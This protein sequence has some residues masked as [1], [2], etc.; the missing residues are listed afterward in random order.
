M[1]KKQEEDNQLFNKKLSEL[2]KIS[3]TTQLDYFFDENYCDLKDPISGQWKTGIIIQRD[4]DDIEVKFLNSNTNKTIYKYNVTNSSDKEIALFRKFTSEES[5]NFNSN[6]V[7]VKE[8]SITNTLIFEA[9][10]MIKVLSEMNDYS[11]KTFDDNFSSPLEMIQDIRGKIYYTFLNIIN[12]NFK[13]EY[14]LMDKMKEKNKNRNRRKNNKDKEEEEDEEMD[15]ET[16]INIEDIGNLLN[17]FLNFSVKFLEW[18]NSNSY[19]GKLLTFNYN[20]MLFDKECAFFSTLYEV[21]SILSQLFKENKFFQNYK[22]PISEVLK[23]WG[24]DKVDYKISTTLINITKNKG[25]DKILTEILTNNTQSLFVF[26]QLS[27][28]L[29]SNGLILLEN[30]LNIYDY[31]SN[32]I[33]NLSIN[34]QKFISFDDIEHYCDKIRRLIDAV[35]ID[36]KEEKNVDSIHLQ[37]LYNLITSNNL[38]LKIK[39]IGLISKIINDNLIDNNRLIKFIQTVHL[40]SSIILGSNIHEEILKRSYHVFSFVLKDP[41]TNNNRMIENLF[42]E[43]KNKNN[44]IA[45]EVKKILIE[46]SVYYN[47]K[48]QNYFFDEILNKINVNNF[49]EDLIDII[50]FSTINTKNNKGVDLLWKIINENEKSEIVDKSIDALSIVFKKKIFDK[51]LVYLYLI[52]S[53]NKIENEDNVQCMKV[54]KTIIQ[55]YGEELKNEIQ[56]LDSKKN[57]MNILIN[58]CNV[59]IKSKDETK[60]LSLYGQAI[61]IE[62][63]LQIIFFIY[64][65]LHK[66]NK[67]EFKHTLTS[68]W[69]IFILDENSKELE[70]NIFSRFLYNQFNYFEESQNLMEY[71]YENIIINEELN[72]TE[73]INYNIFSLFNT[74]FHKVNSLRNKFT[75]VGNYSRIKSVDDLEGFEFFWKI[76]KVTKWEKVKRGIS[77]L[78][79]NLCLNPVSLKNKDDCYSIWK[80]YYNKIYNLIKKNNG[81]ENFTINNIVYFLYQFVKIVEN[82]NKQIFVYDEKKNKYPFTINF[83]L[84]SQNITKKIPVNLEED[85]IINLREKASYY[86]KI[87]F[88]LVELK[89]KNE[90][91]SIEYED[92]DK[93]F[94]SFINSENSGS[95]EIEVNEAPN[96]LY[97]L[98]NNPKKLI[99]ENENIFNELFFLLS[100]YNKYNKDSDLDYNLINDLIY[101]YPVGKQLLNQINEFKFWEILK[102]D[103]SIYSQNY[104]IKIIKSK[105]LNNNW[106]NDLKKD[107]KL[108]RLFLNIFLQFTI[109]EDNK[110]NINEIEYS[111]LDNLLFLID[112]SCDITNNSSYYDIITKCF[113]L[114]YLIYSNKDEKVK[115]ENVIN[116][117]FS[118]INNNLKNEINDIIMNNKNDYIHKICTECL[119]HSK[120][121]AFN[122]QKIFEFLTQNT[123]DIK[124]YISILNYMFDTD[125][126]NEIEKNKNLFDDAFFNSVIMLLNK[127]KLTPEILKKNKRDILFNVNELID[128]I[129]EYIYGGIENGVDNVNILYGYLQI[130]KQ[131]CLDNIEILNKIKSDLNFF[132]KL[133]K[134]C[135]FKTQICN[136]NKNLRTI[137]YEIILI[138]TIDHDKNTKE[139]IDTLSN[140]HN[141]NFWRSNSIYDWNLIP[142]QEKN[143]INLTGLINLGMT[144]YMNSLLQQIFM[145]KE[146]RENIINDEKIKNN[147]IF[148]NLKL[149]LAQLKFSNM[150]YITTKKFFDNITNYEGTPLNAYVQMDVDEFFNLLIDKCNCDEFKNIFEGN[151]SSSYICQ[152]CFNN[153]TSIETFNA[154]DL[155]I[156]NKPNLK[157]SLD[158]FFDEEYLDGDNKYHCSKCNKKVQAQKKTFLKKLPKCLVIVLKRFDF[159]Y[160]RMIKF[161]NNDYYEFPMDINMKDYTEN[162]DIDY[163]YNLKGFIVHKG[164]AD[165]GHYYSIIKHNEKWFEF[166]DVNINEFDIRN[167]ERDGFGYSEDVNDNKNAYLLFYYLNDGNEYVEKIK[168]LNDIKDDFIVNEINDENHKATVN[169]IIFT[170][171]Y[172]N[173][174]QRFIIHNNS[175]YLKEIFHKHFI[176]KNNNIEKYPLKRQ[177]DDII[178]SNID[179][180]L[181]KIINI[182]NDYKKPFDDLFILSKFFIKYFLTIGIRMKN[183]ENIPQMMDISKALLNSSLGACKWLINSFSNI[184]VLEEFLIKNPI[185]DMK[186]LILGILYA[187][188]INLNKEEK[189]DKIINNF[190]NIII[191]IITRKFDEY[192]TNQ[193]TPIYMIL[194][195]FVSFGDKS[196]KYLE[197]LNII[198]IIQKYF[199][200]KHNQDSPNKVNLIKINYK[201]YTE[202]N[203]F[204]CDLIPNKIN[205]NNPDSCENLI[206]LLCKF[207][208]WNNSYISIFKDEYSFSSSILLESNDRLC[209]AHLKYIFK[210]FSE[211]KELLKVVNDSLIP[212]LLNIIQISESN[213][214]YFLIYFFDYLCTLIPTN[215]NNNN[216]F[217]ILKNYFNII[218]QNNQY[219]LYTYFNIKNIVYIFKNYFNNNPDLI[220]KCEDDIKICIQ[221]LIDNPFPP[222]YYPSTTTQLYRN[223]KIDYNKI[224]VNGLQYQMFVIEYKKKSNEV[225]ENLIKILEGK[226]NEIIE[227]PEQ[228]IWTNEKDYTNF[229]F[230]VGDFIK[231]NS[232]DGTVLKVLDEMLFMEYKDLNGKVYKNSW[233]WTWSSIDLLKLHLKSENV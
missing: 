9:K 106:L 65:I 203:D 201:E 60:Q 92:D 155:Q 113:E 165:Y 42:K 100:T 179:N 167:I 118:F 14:E 188:L 183:K 97:T 214:L 132:E 154:L 19:I 220:S 185:F 67:E 177:I 225:K 180:L 23:E 104:L 157:T 17:D 61:N 73:G 117:I 18:V 40:I 112:K 222:T 27:K 149:I 31:Y 148:L 88:K 219:Y 144:C 161:K 89:L 122:K 176:T 57:L 212:L 186:I 85:L 86:F 159:D 119:L 54:F 230:S 29:S 74:F 158:N 135:L 116:S 96:Q 124:T 15:L 208:I 131:L 50:Q 111:C 143:K 5:E 121:D 1:D 217:L 224:K 128:F 11:N 90:L 10:A 63:R 182:E 198:N 94:S 231:A 205:T 156:K 43:L 130:I 140:Y 152:E 76:L 115:N 53:E 33:K 178:N 69:K 209:V 206:I 109:T 136:L 202:E 150:N 55:I 12:N 98:E 81:N 20:F 105:I 195:K 45:D 32:R 221:W 38:P 34:E 229:K 21:T 26:E 197:S 137:T 191:Y 164:T 227:D 189:N 193:I 114:I 83:F 232:Q 24:V 80:T 36:N 64:D 181:P 108:K 51:D 170:N 146:L 84:P 216:L 125:L 139:I 204:I 62:I 78:L 145:N 16:D 107:N 4:E 187:A 110:N 173:F 213:D 223:K 58:N 70:K 8:N 49:T 66:K 56:E 77:S 47:E 7:K 141:L 169:R 126:L 6:F 166:N 82:D 190:I 46:I 162:K 174:I 68:L 120:S 87:P 142:S 151:I 153:S 75:Y 207:I 41:K 48:V 171:E 199:E 194:V 233:L 37:F 25:I 218:E 123:F 215:D 2:T 192:K 102:N 163:N 39:G 129:I 30:R 134:D 147:Q 210:K 196:Y 228:V 35:T 211:D 127:I 72:P 52:A 3:Q 71:I 168:N 184:K 79:I 172:N 13:F 44:S 59:Y 22:E 103:S 91:I 200:T 99:L 175:N 28:V 160:E 93:L 95:L 226:F 138:L 101:F 133:F